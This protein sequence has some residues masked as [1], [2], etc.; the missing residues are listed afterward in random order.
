M[1]KKRIFLSCIILAILGTSFFF[2]MYSPLAFPPKGIWTMPL[3]LLSL[4]PSI[5]SAII[6]SFTCH[7][8]YG[9]DLV[10]CNMTL[11]YIL[12]FVFSLLYSS[13]PLWF[14]IFKFKSKN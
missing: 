2:S 9:S 13:I 14:I 5:P 6:G 1:N 3:I 7:L 11:I 4:A 10:S 12:Y 8:P